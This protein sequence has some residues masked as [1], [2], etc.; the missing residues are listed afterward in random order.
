[1]EDSIG[2]M[3]DLIL[4]CEWRLLLAII[5]VV[6]RD[7]QNKFGSESPYFPPPV[8]VPGVGLYVFFLLSVGE[9]ALVVDSNDVLFYLGVLP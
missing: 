3:R 5:M 1:M 8:H 2:F 9:V 4:R 7:C 6:L